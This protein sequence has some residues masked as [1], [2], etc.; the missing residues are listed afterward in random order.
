M[1]LIPHTF[2]NRIGELAE[3]S[4]G[5]H[6]FTGLERARTLLSFLRV[7]FGI[8]QRLNVG[9]SVRNIKSL[10]KPKKDD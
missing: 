9:I 2:S 8:K 10:G 7:A 5:S 1:S 6:I 3:S 4:M